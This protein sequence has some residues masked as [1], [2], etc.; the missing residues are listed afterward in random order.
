[1]SFLLND[2]L[3]GVWVLV[4]CLLV[5]RS[6]FSCFLGI[7][8][9]NTVLKWSDHPLLALAL[10]L[11]MLHFLFALSFPVMRASWWLRWWRIHLQR[12]TPGF[13]PWVGKIPWRRAWQPI[14]V[15]LPG[16]SPC[17]EEP[18]GLQSM[19]SQRV[20]HKWATKHS[21]AQSHSDLLFFQSY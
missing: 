6:F 2:F 14:P 5:G 10:Q 17:K 15:F 12:G 13:G 7:L 20:G 4:R 18:G 19:G 16:E 8:K 21:S 11:W 1:M 3:H 9:P